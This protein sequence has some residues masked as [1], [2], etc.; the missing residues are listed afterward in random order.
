MN[1]GIQIRQ[2]G[3]REGRTGIG[4][5]I[6]N[7]LMEMLKT[8]TQ[9]TYYLFTNKA[10][11]FECPQRENWEIIVDKRPVSSFV[12]ELISVSRLIRKYRID[13]Y[14]SPTHSLPLFRENNVKYLMTVYDIA[15][16]IL[17]QISINPIKLP[18]RKFILHRSLCNADMIINISRSTASDVARLFNIDPSKLKVIYIGY[19][20]IPDAASL[21]DKAV[22][23][24]YVIDEN[25]FLF[26]GT[27]QPRKNIITIVDGFIRYKQKYGSTDKL[28]LAGSVGWGVDDALKMINDSVYR[29]SIVIAGYISSL[30]KEVLL[31]G[32][33]ALVF[34]VLYEGFGIPVLE[35]M[36][37]GVPVITSRTSSIPEIGGDVVT[38]MKDNTDAAEL[39]ELFRQTA[40]LT[41]EERE[42]IRNQGIYQASQ[43]SWEKTGIETIELFRQV[44]NIAQ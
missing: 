19:D 12:W 38:Y 15:N 10:V 42:R 17:P 18:F 2:I 27:L 35:A 16:Y 31:T 36:S 3:N 30:E 34:P 41:P 1:I 44:M 7:T 21:N 5:T 13:L 40:L 39:S 29:D 33:S 23:R 25:Y 6:H 4:V 24:K 22:I 14:W 11:E 43:F 9:N 26:I 37:R 20:K 8:D 32:S 28:I